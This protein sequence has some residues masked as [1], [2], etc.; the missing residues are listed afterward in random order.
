M[1]GMKIQ[2]LYDTNRQLYAREGGVRGPNL[3][4]SVAHY[5]EGLFTMKAIMSSALELSFQS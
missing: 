5:T 1:Y 3:L 4:H 2:S